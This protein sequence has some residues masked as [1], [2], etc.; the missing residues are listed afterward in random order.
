MSSVIRHTFVTPQDVYRD[1]LRRSSDIS[2]KAVI[3][4]SHYGSIC[5]N[6]T[7]GLL[8]VIENSLISSGEKRSF[9]KRFCALFIEVAQNVCIHSARDING[10]TQ[11]FIIIVKDQSHYKIISGNQILLQDTERLNAKFN[12][13]ENLSKEELHRLYIET[14]SN[15]EFS[16]KGGAGL[17][18]LTIARKS[19]GR[20]THLIQ[21]IDDSFAYLTIDIPIQ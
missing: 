2:D 15:D 6:G 16:T 18:L 11:S 8:K 7:D 21:V 3:L 9:V 13:I 5:A 14:L 10:Q 12:E 4:L 20:F 19:E 1:L 17:G